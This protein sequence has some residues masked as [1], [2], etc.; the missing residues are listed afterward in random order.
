MVMPALSQKQLSVAFHGL[1]SPIPLEFG[2][3]QA[4]EYGVAVF[5]EGAVDAQGGGKAVLFAFDVGITGFGTLPDID[6][7]NLISHFPVNACVAGGAGSIVMFTLRSL[8]AAILAQAAA[9]ECC[10]KF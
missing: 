7:V 3:D 9:K 2:A 10:G 5:R 6:V 4:P 1:L 8:I